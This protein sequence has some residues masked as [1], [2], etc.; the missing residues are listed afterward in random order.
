MAANEQG[1]GW[2][3]VVQAVGAET[4]RRG[5]SKVVKRSDGCRD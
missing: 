5:V 3:N 1:L 4:H 2:A